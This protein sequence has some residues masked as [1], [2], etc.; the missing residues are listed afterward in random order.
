MQDIKK[1]ASGEGWIT[2][3]NAE[4]SSLSCFFGMAG[5]STAKRLS[6]PACAPLPSPLFVSIA[7]KNHLK[8]PILPDQLAGVPL[9]GSKGVAIFEECDIRNADQLTRSLKGADAV[10]N[11]AAVSPDI[12]QDEVRCG[13]D[14]WRVN[15][16]GKFSI[17]SLP[18]AREMYKERHCIGNLGCN[19]STHQV[20][21]FHC[22]RNS[23]SSCCMYIRYTFPVECFA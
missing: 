19:T 21:I 14:M 12:T 2:H 9:T 18:L 8:V 22:R 4:A 13:P 3:D 10:V 17:L 7:C 5:N 1:E 6:A 15:V 20:Y 11:C 23:V 16:D